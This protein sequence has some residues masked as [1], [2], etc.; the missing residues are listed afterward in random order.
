MKKL[1]IICILIVSVIFISGCTSDEQASYDF[2]T[3]SQ[4]NQESDSQNPELIV[5]QN[6]V[7]ELTLED[8]DF[9][10]VPKN[11]VYTV[12]QG[13]LKTYTDT[14]ELGYRKVGEQSTW[15]DQSGRSVQVTLMKYDSN[16][17]LM[18]FWETATRF[19]T[20]SKEE[21]KSMEETSGSNIDFGHLNIGDNS[22][23]ISSIDINTGIESTVIFII[24]KNNFATVSVIDEKD[25]SYSKALRIAKLVK[26]R[27]D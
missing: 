27:L 23:Y 25:K 13:G 1:L 6:D 4:S 18:Q 20:M 21:L 19:D 22:Y 3:G 26:S 11:T 10:A 15:Q 7:P 8:Y 24:H 9:Y 17:G 2:S 5:K 14:L 12:G 16:T